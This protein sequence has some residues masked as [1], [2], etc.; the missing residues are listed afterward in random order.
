MKKLFWVL[1][2]CLIYVP[3]AGAYID[4]T[5]LEGAQT[6]AGDQNTNLYQLNNKEMLAL[7]KLKM[8]DEIS[9]KQENI[10]KT[11]RVEDIDSYIN[12]EK[13]MEDA[14]ALKKILSDVK[15][16]CKNPRNLVIKDTKS[17]YEEI[18]KI[19]HSGKNDHFVVQTLRGQLGRKSR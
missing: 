5:D 9:Y 15:A 17:A 1:C 14:K 19:V 3:T 8:V 16:L 6:S 13:N 18:G 2:F 11:V 4:D 10:G 12:V 7:K